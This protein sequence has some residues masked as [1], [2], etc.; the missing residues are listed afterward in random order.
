MVSSFV[1]PAPVPQSILADVK[2]ISDDDRS[3]FEAF[4]DRLSDSDV[5]DSSAQERLRDTI[6]DVYLALQEPDARDAAVLYI[7]S[8][9]RGYSPGYPDIALPEDE[10]NRLFDEISA[11]SVDLTRGL[12][13]LY[14]YQVGNL[15]DSN[16]KFLSK[17]LHKRSLI[18][19]GILF[20][21][22]G[23]IAWGRKYPSGP[24][25][26]CTEHLD[27]PEYWL[28]LYRES[29]KDIPRTFP[30]LPDIF[31][32][33][34]IKAA[35]PSL[36]KIARGF[37]MKLDDWLN[38][39][40][41]YRFDSIDSQWKW[42]SEDLRPFFKHL[43]DV[44]QNHP[45]DDDLGL[46]VLS[47]GRRCYL[48]DP[49]AMDTDIRKDLRRKAQARLGNL[50]AVVRESSKGQNEELFQDMTRW[51]TGDVI[52]PLRYWGTPWEEMKPLLLLLRAIDTLTVA[53][54]LRYWPDTRMGAAPPDPWHWIPRSIAG[55]LHH[56][57]NDELKKDPDLTDLRTDFA[58]FC[59]D[60]LK[61]KK[62]ISKA[63]GESFAN[64]DFVDPD[65][66]W[67]EGYIKAIGA[68]LV[69][70]KGRSH[71]ILFFSRYRDISESVKS[72]AASA[73]KVI[74]H[75]AGLP[76]GHSPKR[77]LFLAFWYLRQAHY[78]ALPDTGPLNEKGAQSVLS[79]EVSRTTEPVGLRSTS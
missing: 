52:S 72:A 39:E 1:D 79:K 40:C 66:V 10:L 61:T 18:D 74:R 12:L 54:D 34:F 8:K 42:L 31:N 69:N 47:Y 65:P 67:R 68:L 60:R 19:F 32:Q 15:E 25:G 55:I 30:V 73:Y 51:R 29:V 17:L 43:Y 76:K 23:R 37:M 70:P 26:P 64:E 36:A 16:N 71:H 45:G 62:G 46:E 44:D 11:G 20:G 50:R 58:S 59:L 28:Q 48:Y 14:D 63:E 57:L 53:D 38:A 49:E 35:P 78:I 21:E 13:R 22:E 6:A 2:H 75:D 5:V 24:Q 56:Y 77:A 9:F 27:Q 3:I 4:I 41:H 33:F 7:I